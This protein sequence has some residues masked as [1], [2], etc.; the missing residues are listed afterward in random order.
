MLLVG[1]PSS[2]PADTQKINRFSIK[3]NKVFF[4]YSGELLLHSVRFTPFAGSG[5]PD[6]LR[7]IHLRSSPV[8]AIALVR[9]TT[10]ED[11][12]FTATPS[13][14]PCVLATDSSSLSGYSKTILGNLLGK[15]IC[16]K[17]TYHLP[18][19]SVRHI[20]TP[21]FHGVYMVSA[22]SGI[23]GGIY[24]TITSIACSTEWYQIQCF[25]THILL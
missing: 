5:V 11:L 22:M 12:Y 6:V 14:G 23:I 1:F 24:V 10:S 17:F 19:I 20:C 16:V 2:Q 18:Y 15:L 8:G 4:Q 25:G 9:T 13:S 21:L 7:L 3:N